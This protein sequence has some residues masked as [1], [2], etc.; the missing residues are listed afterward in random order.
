MSVASDQKGFVKIISQKMCGKKAESKIA[1]V[2]KPGWKSIE[3]N[4]TRTNTK[5]IYLQFTQKTV[6]NSISISTGRRFTDSLQLRT[7][8]KL[9]KIWNILKKCQKMNG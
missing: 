6:N 1:T 2:P 7:L 3:I 8:N 5:K 9:W 4:G